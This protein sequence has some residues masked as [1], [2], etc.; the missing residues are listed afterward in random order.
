MFQAE[1]YTLW[2]LPSVMTCHLHI[3]V[4]LGEFA[5]GGNILYHIL[6]IMIALLAAYPESIHFEVMSPFIMPRPFIF[7]NQL[8]Q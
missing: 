7:L 8:K 3:V 5:V 6:P 2:M 4:M 1:N